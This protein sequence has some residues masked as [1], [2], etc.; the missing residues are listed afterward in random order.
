MPD[1]LKKMLSWR[2][3][4][5]LVVLI[6]GHFVF[7]GILGLRGYGLLQES[8]LSV[9]D[10]MLWTR[11]ISIPVDNR[12]ITILANDDDQ[13]R[14]GWPLPDDQLAQLFETV[15]TQQPNA[16]GLDI[17][18]DLPVPIGG[19]KG[20]EHLTQVFTTH[21]NIYGIFKFRNPTGASVDPSPALKGTERVGFNDIPS[22]T[23]GTIRRGLLYMG[24]E[25]T[26]YE[27]FGLKLALH[28]LIPKGITPQ[29]DPSNPNA[30]M[31]GKSSL[32]PIVPHFG[33]YVN[34]DTGGFQIMLTYP[35]APSGFQALSFTQVLTATPDNLRKWFKDKIV[36][37][38]VN[39]EAT[40]DFVY[41]P[42]GI[43]LRGEQRVPGS[44]IHA[45]LTSQLIRMALG[46]SRPLHSWTDI[47]ELLWIWLWCLASAFICL[48]ARSL[49]RF[50]LS[51]L[52]GVLILLGLSY[53]AFTN[54][55][56]IIVTAPAL[57][58]TL[59]FLLMLAY[60]SN[61]DK[62]HRAVLMQIFSKHVSKDVAE[63]IWN[64]REQYLNEG[65]LVPQR[66]TATVLFTDLQ[67]FT[68]VSEQMAPTDLMNWLNQYMETMV[69]IVEKE[70]NGQ[71]NKFIGDAIMAVFGV[72]IPSITPEAIAGDAINAVACALAMRN[73]MARLCQI[74][75][76]QGLPLIRMRVGIFTGPVIVG[77]L[78]SVERQEYTVL[79]DT[80]NTASRL[81][82]Y[83][84]TLDADN[85]CRILIG[86]STLQYIGNQLQIEPVGEVSLKGKQTKL[87]I[88]R[89]GS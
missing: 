58:W 65:R 13:R 59:S 17:Y 72:P 46:E 49:W 50:S 10:L 57:G 9:Y 89:V 19:G 29:P 3:S 24:D 80:V 81:E 15:L 62:Q 5:I 87:T 86:D 82:S 14:W 1:I 53:L 7:A 12:I 75:Q 33:G 70:Y 48:W 39:A 36:M 56:W 61:Q 85:I 35:G 30:L 64:E 18:R 73:E 40:P 31:L 26:T 27:V 16:I 63:A 42:F 28:Y 20:Y 78:G 23:G 6:I 4:P 88:Y 47:Q 69:N 68:S 11:S 41:T 71:V 2:Q 52:S 74:W 34:Q 25:N 43:W 38:G 79:G 45:Y 37:I 67:G 83:D 8:E 77:S 44:M 55:V 22:D 84:K 32:E 76:S 66:L 54:D 21:P 51:M 60:L